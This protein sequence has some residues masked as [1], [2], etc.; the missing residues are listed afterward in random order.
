MA[1]T[2][3]TDTKGDA[4]C[5]TNGGTGGGKHQTGTAELIRG[6]TKVEKVPVQLTSFR[7][8]KELLALRPW[9]SIGV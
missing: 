1:G 5:P 2:D 7:E 6:N 4:K 8:M 3:G 9:D